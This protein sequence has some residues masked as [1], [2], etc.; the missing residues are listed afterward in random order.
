M[1]YRKILLDCMP[2]G[3]FYQTYIIQVKKWYGWVT[4]YKAEGEDAFDKVKKV[5][6]TLRQ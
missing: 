5:L 4:I 6:D 2:I 3:Q 1:K